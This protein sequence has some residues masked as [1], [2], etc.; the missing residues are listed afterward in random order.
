MKLSK[1]K[2]NEDEMFKGDR[3]EIK[4]TDE[5]KLYLIKFDYL[6]RCVYNWGIDVEQQYYLNYKSG[7]N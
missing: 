6:S 3:V 7:K 2:L 5:I 1:V 4:P